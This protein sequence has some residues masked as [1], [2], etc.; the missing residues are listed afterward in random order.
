MVKKINCLMGDIVTES[1][2]EHTFY[3]IYKTINN[4]Q[5][6]SQHLKQRTVNEQLYTKTGLPKS[7]VCTT[8]QNTRNA[9][10]MNFHGN[11]SEEYPGDSR[12]D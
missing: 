4:Q 1:D 9:L 6:K 11:R 10:K 2:T 3:Q 8:L 12:D 5:R 7:I